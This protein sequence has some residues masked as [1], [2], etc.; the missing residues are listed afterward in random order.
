MRKNLVLTAS[1]PLAGLQH[2]LGAVCSVV[3]SCFMVIRQ[4]VERVVDGVLC[5]EQLSTIVF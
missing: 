4:R 3:L 5:L 2:F 1:G